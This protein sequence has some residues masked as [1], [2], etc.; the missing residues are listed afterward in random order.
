MSAY[1]SLERKMSDKI[2]ITGQEQLS[3][4]QSLQCISR[5][6]DSSVSIV[7]GLWAGRYGIRFLKGIRFFFLFQNIWKSYWAHPASCWVGTGA[8]GPLVK[9]LRH[10]VDYSAS[11]SAGVKNEWSYTSTPHTCLRG[12]HCEIFIFTL[13]DFLDSDSCLQFWKEYNVLE[14]QPP[15]HQ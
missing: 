8:P 6:W 5:E 7:T 14:T 2:N 1:P 3:H 4:T 9:R 15:S 12:I 11:S 10:E 13:T